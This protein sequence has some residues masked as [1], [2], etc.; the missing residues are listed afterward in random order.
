MFGKKYSFSLLSWSLILSLGIVS[1]LVINTQAQTPIQPTQISQRLGGGWNAFETENTGNAPGRRVGGATRGIC[2][3]GQKPLTA[4][5][6]ESEFGRTLSAHPSIFL[7][8]PS[9]P[10]KTKMQFELVDENENL[11][12]KQE[13]L[14]GGQEG[15]YRIDIPSY[16][17]PL[18]EGKNY[19]WSFTLICNSTDLAASSVVGGWINRIENSQSLARQIQEVSPSDRLQKYTKELL[20]YDLIAN[21]ADLRQSDPNNPTFENTWANL[22]KEVGLNDLATAPL[23]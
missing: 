1:A 4:I 21:L 13:F 9:T 15:I 18:Q 14:G 3:I 11:L 7:Y 2:P 12:Y 17:T 19:L 20:W 23:N 6:P 8:L 5:I 22:L 16:V 10:E